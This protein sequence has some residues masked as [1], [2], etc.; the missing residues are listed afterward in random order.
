M[1]KISKTQ[2]NRYKDTDG[3]EIIELFEKSVD[4]DFSYKDML[5][6]AMRFDPDYFNNTTEKERKNII[7]G[8]EFYDQLIAD[9]I[10]TEED[11]KNIETYSNF[12]LDLIS[13]MSQPDLENPQPI[14]K[15]SETAFKL[16]LTDNLLMSILLHAYMP[17]VFFPNFFVM[18]FIYLKKIASKYDIE[19]PEVPPRTKY[20]DR[21][22]YYVKLCNILCEF[23][24]ENKLTHAEM[25]AFLYDYEIKLIK[26][27]MEAETAS[28]QQLPRPL[29]AWFLVG[30]YREGERNMTRG[31]WQGNSE[32]KKGD[33]LVFYEKSPVKSINSVWRAQEAGVIDPFF[34]YYSNTYIGNKQEI[35][36]I[37]LEELRNDTYF[38]NHKLVHKQFQGGSGWALNAEDYKQLK[39]ILKKKDFDISLLPEL[40]AHE[41]PKNIDY[42]EKESAVHKYQVIPLLNSMGWTEEN[43]DILNQVTLH[44]G[45]GEFSK[46]GRTDVSLHP[47][48]TGLKKARVV[49]EEKYWM[50]NEIQIEETFIQGASYANIQKANVLVLCDKYQIIVYPIGCD[51]DFHSHQRII[52]YWDEISHPDKFNELKKLLA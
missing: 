41:A 17:K 45:H 22:M 16:P 30:T 38:K 12:Y 32:T 43:G 29:Q 52:F 7:E 35:P 46:R 6:L 48:G 36:P 20:F 44:L 49:I 10:P 39:R 14:E 42:S 31:F 25:C 13:Y 5:N 1:K 2:W 8:F 4:N 28:C 15:L 34:L 3:K 27:E 47:F 9:N 21:C 26:E 24:N 23:A 18:Q 50:E 37:S 33:V 40:M 19:L 11:L 51:N